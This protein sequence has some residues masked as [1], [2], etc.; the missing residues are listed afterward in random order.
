[1]YSKQYLRQRD[2][3]AFAGRRELNG[4]LFQAEQDELSAAQLNDYDR[5]LPWES[6]AGLQRRL[7][8]G[9]LTSR[10][11]VLYFC[12]RIQRL[13]ALNAVGELNPEA[14]LLADALDAERRSAGARGPLH[15]IPLL[16]KDNIATGDQMHTTA[17]AKVLE[18]A[19]A[20]ADAF[21]AQK[22][23]A[24]GAILLGK[25][26]MSEWANFMTRTSANGFSVLG[27]QVRCPYGRFDVSGS[28]SGSAAAVAAGLIP[29]ALGTETCGSLISP[30]ACNSL[31][32]LK[33]SLGLVSRKR[34]IPITGVTDTAGPMAR[35][36][37]D[38]AL[39]FQAIAGPDPEDPVT[40]GHAGPAVDWT[41]F[42]DAGALR[43]LRIGFVSVYKP[44]SAEREMIE[45]CALVLQ[46]CGAEV[47]LAR[48]RRAAA[49]W[50]EILQVFGYGMQHDLAA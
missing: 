11:L 2:T 38:L 27:G 35:S 22:L 8:A 9:E 10:R 3:P 30:G 21:V 47:V 28:S 39:V 1:M 16:L 23:R 26:N 24:A 42:L 37:A 33:P 6:I 25:T 18:H 40:L 45:D 50:N 4:S 15:G 5:W 34:I 12:R 29:A 20:G 7:Q 41:S 36:V 43:G 19:R 49:P 32:V 31:A 17:G 14:L 13:A 46:E 48:T 44:G